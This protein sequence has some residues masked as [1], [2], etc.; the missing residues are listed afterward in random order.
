[1]KCWRCHGRLIG[2]GAY[3]HRCGALQ[4]RWEL[5]LVTHMHNVA[6]RS[7][8]VVTSAPRK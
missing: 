7:I 8:C 5:F 4:G 1:M 6:K 3:C 2:F